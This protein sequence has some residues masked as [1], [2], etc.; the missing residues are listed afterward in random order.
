MTKTIIAQMARICRTPS[1]EGHRLG[2]SIYVMVPMAKVRAWGSDFQ[3]A[4]KNSH[5]EVAICGLTTWGMFPKLESHFDTAK[6]E[7]IFQYNLEP[8]GA[9]N[10][11]NSPPGS[12]IFEASF[13]C[14]QV[15]DLSWIW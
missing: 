8:K 2:I 5:S 13:E 6:Y 11:G 12:I 3:A 9:H 1:T 15:S 10:F 14:L 4:W 7:V